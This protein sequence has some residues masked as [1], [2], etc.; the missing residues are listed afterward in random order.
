M[1]A[2]GSVRVAGAD[3]EEKERRG[4]G[5]Y[6]KDIAGAVGSEHLAVRVWRFP[7]GGAM[8]LH[9]HRNQEEIYHLLAGGPQDLQV[10]EETIAVA[11]GDWVRVSKDT[12]RRIVNSSDRDGH[13]LIV[14]APPGDG[15]MDGIRIDPETGEEIPR[16]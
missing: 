2:D 11:D 9:R 14:A 12:S 16:T 6:S 7:P 8:P 13:W 15:I 4:G 3:V 5:A 1:S 10:G